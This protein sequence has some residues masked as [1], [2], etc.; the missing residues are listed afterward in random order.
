MSSEKS[1]RDTIFPG[2]VPGKIFSFG[3]HALPHPPT[4][5]TPPRGTYEKGDLKEK[6]TAQATRKL[7]PPPYRSPDK[8]SQS[9]SNASSGSPAPAKRL[10]GG[11]NPD[12]PS[13]DEDEVVGL[14]RTGT[15]DR[16][17]SRVTY[18]EFMVLDQA[19]LANIGCDDTREN[20]LK[21]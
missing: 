11:P 19:G 18:H 16:A 6:L 8:R 10:R 15:K 7:Q 20:N 14:G 13:F 17:P 1:K 2:S 3:K 21:K 12:V 4:T 9:S 5:S